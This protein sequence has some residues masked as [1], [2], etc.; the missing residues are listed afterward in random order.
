MGQAP[1]QARARSVT[2][3]TVD[4]LLAATARRYQFTIVTDNEADFRTAGIQVINPF[5]D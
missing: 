5:A 1:A 4:S 3:P 2:L